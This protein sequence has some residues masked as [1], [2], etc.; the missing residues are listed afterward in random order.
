MKGSKV[1]D[2][3]KSLGGSGRTGNPSKS[4]VHRFPGC[5]GAAQAFD[6]DTPPPSFPYTQSHTATQHELSLAPGPRR[7]YKD[8]MVSVEGAHCEALRQEVPGLA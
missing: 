4:L 2:F 6:F 8:A 1:W 5:P 3:S 7:G